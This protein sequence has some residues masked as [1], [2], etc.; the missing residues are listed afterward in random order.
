MNHFCLDV[1]QRITLP[2]FLDFLR[3]LF[4]YL[5][6]VDT[7]NATIVDLHIPDLAYMV[8]HE[9]VVRHRFPNLVGGFNS[10]LKDKL[11]ELTNDA[12]QTRIYTTTF[13]T[14]TFTNPI[15]AITV[16]GGLKQLKAGETIEITVQISN[17]SQEVWYGYGD[18][19]VLL[20]YHWNNHDGTNHT[21]DGIRTKL[22]EPEFTPGEIL[23][24]NLSVMVPNDKGPARLLLTMV[25]E[26]VY[27]LEDKGFQHA[28][29]DVEIL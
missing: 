14:P 22:L 16:L 13:K 20:S 11:N 7:D 27:W 5:Y 12:N 25:Q 23:E 4:P 28:E 26:G 15:G 6:A 2:D 8:M 9:H 18:H 29:L 17:Q 24:Q 10:S 3:D 1:L 19:P 21:Y